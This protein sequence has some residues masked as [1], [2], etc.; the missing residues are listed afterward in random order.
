MFQYP[1]CL[2]THFS[3]LNAIN[4]LLCIRYETYMRNLYEQSLLYA[5]KVHL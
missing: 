1:N 4:L 5:Q 3:M 2:Q